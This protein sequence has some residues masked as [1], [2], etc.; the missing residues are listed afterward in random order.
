MPSAPSEPEKYSIDEIM[1]RLKAPPSDDPSNGLLVTRA[2]GSQAIKVRKRKR[3]SSQPQNEDFR[4]SRRALILQVSGALILLFTAVLAIGS[5]I[6]YA[7]SSPFREKLI[8]DIGAASGAKVDLKQFRMNPRTANADQLVFAWPQGNILKRFTLANLEAEISPSSFLGK[9][10]NGEE[11]TANS[12]TLNLQIPN[13]DNSVTYSPTKRGDSEI[14]FNR[15]RAHTFHVTV[16][17]EAAPAIS[18]NQSEASL[19]PRNVNGHPQ[20]SLYQGYFSISGWQKLRLDRALIEFRGEEADIIGLRILNEK[21]DRGSLELSGTVFPYR[22]KQTSS[23]AVH[24]DS[25]ELSGLIG[26][27]LGRFFSGR[28]DSPPTTKSNCFSFIPNGTLPSKLEVTFRAALTSRIEVQGLPFLFALSRILDYEWLEKPVFDTNSSGHVRR[29]GDVITLRD[30]NF[31]SKG[32][33]ALQ[34]DISI[35]KD[36][37]LTGSLRIGVA[38]GIIATSKNARIKSLFSQ[39]SNDFCWVT[40]QMGGSASA[41]T[42]TL[43]ELFAATA[44]SQ[45]AST[46]VEK[47]GS[48]FEELTR[49]K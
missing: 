1:D 44:D 40:L 19:T 13:G 15:Y 35:A 46:P 18:L 37:T 27:E 31:E 20:L 8:R 33:L 3:R 26:P 6:I 11:I 12:G 22:P 7:N 29:E 24:L 42:D 25:F 34:G 49:P 9:S 48:S 16:G 32:H 36:Q 38:A 23:L 45:D 21:D 17:D 30:L 14:S 47:L 5:G 39:S 10:L 41:P 28:V 2:D 43:K 4:R